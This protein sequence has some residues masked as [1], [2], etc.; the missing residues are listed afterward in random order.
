MFSPRDFK[1]L[2]ST[3]FTTWAINF[4]CY[5]VADNVAHYKDFHILCKYLNDLFVKKITRVYKMLMFKPF[6]CLMSDGMNANDLN[7]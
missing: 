2:V 6:V 5:Q 4:Y 1:S 3:N 7:F